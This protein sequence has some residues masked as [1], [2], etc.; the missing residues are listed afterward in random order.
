MEISIRET[1][2]ERQALDTSLV[3]LGRENISMHKE[4]HKLKTQI[5]QLKIAQLFRES[6]GCI[7]KDS[8]ITSNKFDKNTKVN[9]KS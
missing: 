2:V 6:L 5:A 7:Q 9:W 1:G 8:G 4:L 3:I